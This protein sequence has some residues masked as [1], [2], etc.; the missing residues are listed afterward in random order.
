MN[1]NLKNIITY[2]LCFL[3]IAGINSVFAIKKAYSRYNIVNK[4]FQILPYK[5]ET[6]DIDLTTGSWKD[7]Y[8]GKVSFLYDAKNINIINHANNDGIVQV[9]AINEDGDVIV[10]PITISL[11]NE[12]IL[13]NV[14]S[15]YTIQAKAS[16]VKGNYR[17]AIS[18][19]NVNFGRYMYKSA[20]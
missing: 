6:Y 9:R 2:V 15:K 19:T 7:I 5:S 4:S 17:F 20:K 3:T 12:E 13:K 10:E 1:K 18:E 11:G 14:Y 16:E 8:S